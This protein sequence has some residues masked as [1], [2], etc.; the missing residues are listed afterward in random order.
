M[1]KLF[2][3]AI[4]VASLLF[5]LTTTN[6][7]FSQPFPQSLEAGN[8]SFGSISSV[9]NDE[10]GNPLWIVTGN[11]KGNILSNETA[12]NPQGITFSANVRMVMIN[13]SAEHGH[14]I[15]NFNVTD[16]SEENGIKTF[17]GTSDINLFDRIV[18]DVPSSIRVLGEDVI[19]IWVD[20]TRVEEH[21]GNTPIYG[22]VSDDE[23]GYGPN[24]RDGEGLNIK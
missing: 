12:A 20:P 17:N 4:V 3:S 23:R 5:T 24:N 15:T 11:W 1:K 14:A 19:S 6:L 21:Y 13:G 16:V 10:S 7:A 18:E 8:Y 22:V 9:Q 2:L